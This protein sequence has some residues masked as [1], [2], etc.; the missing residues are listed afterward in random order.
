MKSTIPVMLATSLALLAQTVALPLSAELLAKRN[1]E[2]C[3]G[4]TCYRTIE[5]LTLKREAE[6]EASPKY[7]P[8]WKREAEPKYPPDW[9]RD[10]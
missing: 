9:K 7:P 8:D 4:A 2:A 1:P 10:A 5:A 3:V 6:P